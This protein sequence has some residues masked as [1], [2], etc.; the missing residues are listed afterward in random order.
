MANFSFKSLRAR[1]F[2][3]SPKIGNQSQTILIDTTNFKI[4][5]TKYMENMSS[6]PSL[7]SSKSSPSSKAS[8]EQEL[9]RLGHKK[10]QRVRNRELKQLAVYEILDR[11]PPFHELPLDPSAVIDDKSIENEREI[12]STSS[13]SIISKKK[14]T[15]KKEQTLADLYRPIPNIEEVLSYSESNS[16]SNLKSQNHHPFWKTVPS[17]CNPRLAVLSG[18]G[19]ISDQHELG[20][21]IHNRERYRRKLQYCTRRTGRKS[22]NPNS[23]HYGNSMENVLQRLRLFVPR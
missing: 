8:S 21:D 7:P 3:L 17:V 20:T 15:E 10:R 16:N 12:A 11:L 19:N 6:S 14:K 9:Y 13:D 22:H 2:H 23:T 18:Q 4:S 1:S 5:S